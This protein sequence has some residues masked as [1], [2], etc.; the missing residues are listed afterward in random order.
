V[1]DKD[2]ASDWHQDLELY[3][4]ARRAGKQLVLLVYPGENHGL[5]VRGE[6]DRLSRRI[7]AWF[8]TY[9]KGNDRARLG[10]SKGVSVLEREKELSR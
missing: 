1:G 7:N 6:P 8:D 4:L 9:L 3:N 2:G 5:A 10:F